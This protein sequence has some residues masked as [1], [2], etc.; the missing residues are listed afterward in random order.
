MSQKSNPSPNQAGG[1]QPEGVNPDVERS[2]NP[3]RGQA[4]P[5]KARPVDEVTEDEVTE[6]ESD[7]DRPELAPGG[8]AE[9]RERQEQPPRK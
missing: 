5:G 8:G 2:Q 6:D 4:G 1:E 7:A 3:D 9:P